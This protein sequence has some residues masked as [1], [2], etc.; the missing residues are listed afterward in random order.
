M[1]L[2]VV[3]EVEGGLRYWSGIEWWMMQCP[4]VIL[5][6]FRAHSIGLTAPWNISLSPPPLLIPPCVLSAPSLWNGKLFLPVFCVSSHTFYSFFINMC[7]QPHHGWSCLFCYLSAHLCSTINITHA[8][9]NVLHLHHIWLWQG[10]VKFTLIT[11]VSGQAGWRRKLNLVRQGLV[12]C[13]GAGY[14]VM[15]PKNLLHAGCFQF[16]ELFPWS[17]ETYLCNRVKLHTVI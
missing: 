14:R 4:Y 3:C 12:R 13:I 15:L 2:N 5:K 16:S 6:T 17:K 9:T 7:Y 1:C 8:D 11:R 10:H